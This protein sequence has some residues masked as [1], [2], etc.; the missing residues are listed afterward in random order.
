MRQSEMEHSRSNRD[1]SRILAFGLFCSV[2]LAAC[3]NSNPAT[4]EIDVETKSAVN[5][6]P[7]PVSRSA[8]VD[9]ITDQSR[10]PNAETNLS[11]EPAI[12]SDTMIV[13]DSS[14]SMWGQIDGVAKRDIARQALRDI[15]PNLSPEGNIGLVAYGHRREG[16][17]SDIEILHKAL[18]G[19][20]ES[21]IATADSLNARGKTPLTQAVRIAADSLSISDEPATV[22]LITD[23]LE[24]CNADPCALGKELENDGVDFTAH[25]IGFGLN[26]NEG[27]QVAC[28]AEE[29]GGLYIEA[30]NADE[31]DDAFEVVADS[32]K[33]P[34][35]NKKNGPAFITITDGSVGAT[36]SFEVTWEGPQNRL[37]SLVVRSLD[38]EKKYDRVY[39]YRETDL[40]PAALTA[41]ELPGVY[42]VHYETRKGV[43]LARDQLTVID[44]AASLVVPSDPI[45]AGTNFRVAFE[46]PENEFDRIQLFTE[47]SDEDGLSGWFVSQAEN[48]ELA[49]L[50]P[51]SPGAYSVRYLL[52]EG[53][54]IAEQPITIISPEASISPP[55][56]DVVAGAYF[57][58]GVSNEPGQSDK[59]IIVD[60]QNSNKP[61]DEGYVQHA[62][63]GEVRLLAPEQTGK[64][65]MQYIDGAG[66]MLASA[67]LTVTAPDTSIFIPEQPIKVGEDIEIETNPRHGEFDKLVLVSQSDPEIEID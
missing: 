10:L 13:L 30:R 55:E 33:A 53:R 46:G 16:D 4:K 45:S 64:F 59:V 38:G 35:E 34:T 18:P 63:N 40:S 32:E 36:A 49:L 56:N 17:C 37:D 24:P 67:I 51:P 54:S 21:L 19:E 27:Q 8:A 23:G 65:E 66:D 1:H 12:P 62:K 3:G 44:A 42:E 2:L 41:P 57:A 6:A 47:N 43:S 60:P 15:L 31:L 39:V 48:G 5:V 9:D 50:A 26:Q 58:T 14:G 22:I 29:T 52:R 28:L 11:S 7:P 25:V 61:I 20:R